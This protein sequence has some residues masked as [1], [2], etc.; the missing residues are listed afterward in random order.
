MHGSC[1][2]R[3][4]TKKQ[5]L[6]H[7]NYLELECRNDRELLIKLISNFQTT[8][9]N[10]SSKNDISK[11]QLNQEEN[12]IALKKFNEKVQKILINPDLYLCTIQE[13]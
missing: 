11:D 5:R 8:L 9:K 12:Y 3:F 4:K 6:I 2:S 13:I 10:F 7:H 1:I